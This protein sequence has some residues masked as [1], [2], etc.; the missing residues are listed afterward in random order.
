MNQKNKVFL[1]IKIRKAFV[2][3]Y[4]DKLWSIAQICGLG[5]RPR[6]GKGDRRTAVEGEIFHS[7]KPLIKRFVTVFQPFPQRT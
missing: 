3:G 5:G 1:K 6:T 4:T 7:R 2:F